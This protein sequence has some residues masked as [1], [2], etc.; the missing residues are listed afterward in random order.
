MAPETAAILYLTPE[1]LH[2]PEAVP[3][4]VPGADGTAVM[5]IVIDL[6]VVLPQLP[7]SD[8]T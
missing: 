4:M 3:V 7:P 1:E 5:A 8:L 2:K 6:Q